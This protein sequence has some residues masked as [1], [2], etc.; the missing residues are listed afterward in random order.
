MAQAPDR[1]SSRA[2]VL[3][4]GCL[5]AHQCDHSGGDVAALLNLALALL[6]ILAW[7]NN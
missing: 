5:H 2:G 4:G 7:I 6:Q 1:L 3:W